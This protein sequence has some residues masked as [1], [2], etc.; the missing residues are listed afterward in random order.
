MMGAVLVSCW[1]RRS[2]R[3]NETG[4]T[5]EK[6]TKT[7][8]PFLR[9]HFSF[10]PLRRPGET[11][12]APSRYRRKNAYARAFLAFSVRFLADFSEWC[13]RIHSIPLIRTLT[14]RIRR[15]YDDTTLR[16]VFSHS[17]RAPLRKYVLFFS[18]S[19]AIHS[20]RFV[21]VIRFPFFFFVLLPLATSFYYAPRRTFARSQQNT[22]ERQDKT[23][24][25]TK[26]VRLV[27]SSFRFECVTETHRQEE[28][29]VQTS[30]C[31]RM[32]YNRFE[33]KRIEWAERATNEAE[34]ANV[35]ETVVRWAVYW[36]RYGGAGRG[37]NISSLAS[38][39][40]PSYVL[41]GHGGKG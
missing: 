23:T 4:S 10:S 25:R 6:K 7:T 35:D 18:L 30:W 2:R 22:D 15:P 40:M 13:A 17:P 8:K 5:A 41:A 28:R 19:F 1:W 34:Q 26:M 27:A 31:A 21:S 29:F 11:R 36:R 33:S 32:S 9:F 24:K 3:T 14:I 20:K 38:L 12:C 16:G 39:L 37:K